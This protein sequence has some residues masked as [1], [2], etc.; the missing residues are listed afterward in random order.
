MSTD[1]CILGKK[2]ESPNITMKVTTQGPVHQSLVPVAH[3]ALD[4]KICKLPMSK[5]CQLIATILDWGQVTGYSSEGGQ[6]KDHTSK[7]LTQLAKQFQ[8]SF[9]I[10]FS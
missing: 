6:S 1:D 8:E 5:V 2:P 3:V 7:F 9:V 10:F 4:N